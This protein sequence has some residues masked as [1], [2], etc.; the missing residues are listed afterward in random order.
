[1]PISTKKSKLIVVAGPTASGKTAFAIK[2][3]KDIGGEIINADSRQVYMF[4]NI[5]TNK[6]V[7]KAIKDNVLKLD[8]WTIPQVDIENSKI[9]GWLF[10]VLKPDENF[11]VA[12]Y[13]FIARGVIKNINSRGKTAVLVGGTG[14]YIDAVVQNYNINN[15]LPNLVLREKLENFSLSDLQEELQRLDR[16][17]FDN[18]NDSE[19]NNA[20]RLIRMI[21]KLQVPHSFKKEEVSNYLEYEFFYL[22]I[23]REVLYE[24]INTRAEMMFKQGF[25][26]EVQSLIKN[27]YRDSKPMQ[28]MGY[29]EVLDYL[30]GNLTLGECIDKTKQAHRNYARRQITWF[31]NHQ[32]G[33]PTHFKE[34]S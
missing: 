25:V 2:L 30:D 10:D 3:A 16:E 33:K 4:M 26:E 29:R 6:G 22:D 32:Y 21:E 7:I 8:N 34:I 31:K 11:S 14:L 12:D 13:Q 24:K 27:G 17:F 18:L 1:M 5:G 23:P 9:T 19:K 20:R 15:T 28:G